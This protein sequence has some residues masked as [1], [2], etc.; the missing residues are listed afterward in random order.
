M[1]SLTIVDNSEDIVIGNTSLNSTSS[2]TL[3]KN[4]TSFENDLSSIKKS[5]VNEVKV[6][7]SYYPTDELLGELYRVLVSKS[8]VSIQGS[9]PDRET[10]QKLAID[11]KIH[12]FTDIMVAKDPSTG[13]RFAV[14]QKPSWEL[15]ATE[16]V[17]LPL[18]SKT[19]TGTL[20][21]WKMTVTDLG[22]DDLVDENELLNDG[23]VPSAAP[24]DCGAGN[25]IAVKKRACAN[26]TC[27]LAETETAADKEN[28]ALAE[29]AAIGAASSVAASSVAP[30]KS[31]CGNCYKGDA[32]R[33]AS[34][35]FLGKPAFEAGKEKLVLS[36]TDDI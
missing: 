13:E 9:I 30:A 24:V 22:E 18:K 4:S 10:G 2:V 17:A 26:C 19:P 14:C 3:V 16:S 32:F 34:C 7:S 5:S 31:A 28:T 33:C 12:G 27:G 1:T 20:K 6:Y 35:P 21:S 25:E 36:I 15:G 11:L 23:I 8:K 29:G